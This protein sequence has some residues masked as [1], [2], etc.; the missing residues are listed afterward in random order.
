MTEFI[1]EHQTTRFSLQ[2]ALCLARAADLSYRNKDE[3]E[4][5]AKGKWGMDQIIYFDEP[6][7]GTQGFVMTN[8]DII[9]IAFR[10][11]EITEPEDISTDLRFL[12]VRGPFAGKVHEGFYK[13]LNMAW[14][15]VE[16]AISSCR[17][18]PKSL[19]FTGH[20]LGAA[21]AT[22]AVAR[23]RDED[24][25]V[26]GLYTFGQPRVGDRDFARNFNADFGK[27]TFR[28][29]NN[30]DVVTRIPPRELKYSH[31]GTLKYFTEDG[32]LVDDISFWNRFLDRVH[33]RMADFLEWGTD[34]LTD[35][36]MPNYVA[37][38]EAVI[39]DDVPG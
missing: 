27:Y 26:D 5:I 29:V 19:W 20:S 18:R 28:F 32:R 10:G 2:N 7:L 31:V 14:P 30:N 4:S 13:A 33:G 6:F 37:L 39:V 36:N 34:G 11:T 15:A 21:L 1:F 24:Q 3:A 22:L 17:T 38:I 23:M 9:V 35:H 8:D 16:Q 25:P 12:P